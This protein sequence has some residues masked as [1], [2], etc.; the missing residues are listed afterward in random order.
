MVDQ[1]GKRCS[2]AYL[3]SDGAA[4][5]PS[6]GLAMLYVDATFA[7]IERSALRAVDVEGTEVPLLPSTLDVEQEL[8]GPI[9][10]Q[11]LLDHTIHTIYQLQSEAVGVNLATQ[12]SAGK[13]FCAP[14]IFR[15][16]YQPQTLFLVQN[17]NGIFAL[18]GNALGFS[19]I[20]R[21]AE[22]PA[23]ADDS[24]DLAEDLDFTMM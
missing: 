13:L 17:E 18:I 6:G 15:D 14:F 3:S 21:D 4:L 20:S 19:F 23:P 1:D 8:E 10:P 2:S 16:D 11:R 5:V 22:P 12:L 9:P 7:T 24:D